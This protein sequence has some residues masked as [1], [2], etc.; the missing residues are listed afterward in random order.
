MSW[1]R[2]LPFRRRN[3]SIFFLTLSITFLQSLEIQYRRVWWKHHIKW[4]LISPWQCEHLW[5]KR[6]FIYFVREWTWDWRQTF[7]PWHLQKLVYIL[8]FATLRL[9]VYST[10]L[11]CFCICIL[12]KHKKEFSNQSNLLCL[13]LSWGRW[14]SLWHAKTNRQH[15]SGL[16]I[17][18]FWKWHEPLHHLQPI[19]DWRWGNTQF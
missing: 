9:R 15:H 7:Q 1:G 2:I 14:R 10:S 19:Y 18:S 6:N 11:N 5:Q 16:F 8:Y 3:R 17:L 13:G 12:R 4:N